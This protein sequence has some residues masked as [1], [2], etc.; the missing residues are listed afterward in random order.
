[1]KF[2]PRIELSVK[3]YLENPTSLAHFDRFLRIFRV[4]A[5]KPKNLTVSPCFH[6]KNEVV[7]LGFGFSV[8]NYPGN[9]TSLAHL[10]RFLVFFIYFQVQ[11][12]N[13]RPSLRKRPKA[14]NSRRKVE[15]V[16]APSFWSGF[17]QQNN[18]L[19]RHIQNRPPKT[20]NKPLC[21]LAFDY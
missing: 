17:F 4:L 16:V 11:N 14:R 7:Y 10:S 13:S 21:D 1:M 2:D 18:F 15:K 19:S 5:K 8:K 6:P 9:P 20:T 3:I 12:P